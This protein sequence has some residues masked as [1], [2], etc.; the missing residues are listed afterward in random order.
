MS[1]SSLSPVLKGNVVVPALLYLL[2]AV[3]L[4]SVRL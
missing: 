4:Q 1:A 3:S 2:H